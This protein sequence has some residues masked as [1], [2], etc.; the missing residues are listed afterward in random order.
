MEMS[1]KR[2]FGKLNDLC[3]MQERIDVSPRWRCEFEIIIVNFERHVDL[4]KR[5]SFPVYWNGDNRHV[6]R[7][8]YFSRKGSLDWFPLRE[9]V[10][11]QLEFA[12]RNRV[13]HCRTFQPS[14]LFVSRVDMQGSSPGLHAI[15]TG[16]DDT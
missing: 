9:D 10:A 14:G 2:G 16:E 12:Y 15:F 11:E 8:H 4:L 3:L 6:L 1:I 5:H 7:G 13:W